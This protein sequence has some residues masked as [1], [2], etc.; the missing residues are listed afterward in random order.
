MP[1]FCKC[2]IIDPEVFMITVRPFEKLADGRKV[3]MI[4][5]SNETISVK[6]LTLGANIYSLRV[7]GRT[8]KHVDISLGLSTAAEYLE[9]RSNFGMTVGPVANR[10]SN[11]HFTLN[12]T[13]YDLEKNNC[14]NCL[15]SASAG[16]AWK[17]WDYTVSLKSKTP[18]CQ[19][20]VTCPN[21]EG[22]WPG[23]RT[24]SLKYTLKKHALVLEYSAT[25]DKDTY[26]NLTNHSYFNL[27][28]NASENVLGY[29]LKLKS[30][31]VTEVTPKALIPTGKILDVDSTLDFRKGKLLGDNRPELGY[32]NYYIIDGYPAFRSFGK[33]ENPDNGIVMETLSDLPGMQLFTANTLKPEIID[34]YGNHCCNFGAI[35]IETAFF[36]DSPNRNWSPNCLFKAG[37][38][39]NT[40]TEYRFSVRQRRKN[41]AKGKT[42]HKKG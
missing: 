14:G 11:G 1:L 8:G 42:G 4:E 12:G 2:V 16:I 31:K 28:G 41:G 18:W 9:R 21:G 27:S 23:N 22:G 15:H 36:T 19:F 20:T 26:L 25:T 7:P 30:S 34:K 32:D 13:E 38:V 40:R 24:I 37:E 6:L 35:C 39:L 5:L 10:V 17:V 33:V 3:D 29:K